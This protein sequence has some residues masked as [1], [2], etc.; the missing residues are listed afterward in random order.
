MQHPDRSATCVLYVTL[1][2]PIPHPKRKKFVPSLTGDINFQTACWKNGKMKITTQ[3][4]YG[5]T[6]FVQDNPGEPVPEETFTY[7]Q[8]ET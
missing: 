2:C 3:P 4:F 7:V 1:H 5:S 8:T 6:D